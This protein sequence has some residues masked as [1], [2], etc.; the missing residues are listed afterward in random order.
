MPPW[1]TDAVLAWSGARRGSRAAGPG[2]GT[3]APRMCWAA[4]ACP[5]GAASRPRR[6]DRHAPDGQRLA[7]AGARDGTGLTLHPAAAV[8]PGIPG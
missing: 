4:K 5:A 8:G 3:G 6:A 7:Q 1:R 2:G